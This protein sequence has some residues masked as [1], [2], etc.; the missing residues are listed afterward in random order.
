MATPR[1]GKAKVKLITFPVSG[2]SVQVLNLKSEVLN[3]VFIL[4]QQ[5]YKERQQDAY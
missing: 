1:R 3:E 2:G 5:P 4:W